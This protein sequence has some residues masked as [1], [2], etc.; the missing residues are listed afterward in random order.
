MRLPAAADGISRGPACEWRKR[1]R[2][3]AGALQ[4]A[5]MRAKAPPTPVVWRAREFCLSCGLCCRGT[6]MILTRID[7]ERLERLG[8]R[9]SDFAVFDGSFHRLKNVE[10]RCF[11]YRNGRCAVYR[12][13][14]LGCSMY[15][16]VINAENLSVEVDRLCPLAQETRREELRRA[17]RVARRILAELKGEYG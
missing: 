13:R 6:E 7:I 5:A 3:G 8:Y 15:P 1:L 17:E 2:A 4:H 14:P 11:F 10:G 9:R 16:I 12:Y